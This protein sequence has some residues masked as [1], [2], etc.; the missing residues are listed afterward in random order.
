MYAHG[1]QNEIEDVEIHTA[2]SDLLRKEAQI[3]EECHEKQVQEITAM[4]MLL[5]SVLRFEINKEQTQH[6]QHS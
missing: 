2:P 6:K 1:G 3:D 4:G 5:N